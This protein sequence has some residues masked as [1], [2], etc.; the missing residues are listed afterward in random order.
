[1]LSPCVER[2][3]ELHRT[4]NSA[5]FM[6]NVKYFTGPPVKDECNEYSTV[7]TTVFFLKNI[8]CHL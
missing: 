5:P 6:L 7:E 2:D 3:L 1:M 4:R 8:Y